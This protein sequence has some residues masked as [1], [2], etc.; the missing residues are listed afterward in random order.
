MK[1][2]SRVL[3][4]VCRRWWAVVL[5]VLAVRLFSEIVWAVVLAVKAVMR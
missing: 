4:W 3:D 5:T 2:H 1:R